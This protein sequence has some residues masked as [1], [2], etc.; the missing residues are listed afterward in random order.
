[1][2][3]VARNFLHFSGSEMVSK[4]QFWK[5]WLFWK[6]LVERREES[7]KRKGDAPT[8][9]EIPIT[10]DDSSW[11]QDAPRQP[12]MGD[13]QISAISVDEQVDFSVLTAA[14]SD[15]ENAWD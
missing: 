6:Y 5:A 11:D 8:N 10:A 4:E 9:D 14:D 7:D 3:R 12:S 2:V 1:M 15:D 13:G